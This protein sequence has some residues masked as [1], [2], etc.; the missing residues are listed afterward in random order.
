MISIN[1][2]RDEW[3]SLK[4]KNPEIYSLLN[5]VRSNEQS[6]DYCKTLDREKLKRECEFRLLS[7]F[8]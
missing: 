2:T 3:L 6:L 1:F 7:A 8:M 5:T 4:G